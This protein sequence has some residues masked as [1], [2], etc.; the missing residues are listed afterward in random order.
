MAK[1]R[2][3]TRERNSVKPVRYTFLWALYQKQPFTTAQQQNDWYALEFPRSKTRFCPDIP[4]RLLGF[5]QIR[6]CSDTEHAL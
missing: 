2:V 1:V 6:F 4:N 3:R 5:S